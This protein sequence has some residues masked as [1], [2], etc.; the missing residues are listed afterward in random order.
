MHSEDSVH[1]LSLEGQT[2]VWQTA[3]QAP[4]RAALRY[5]KGVWLVGYALSNP[6]RLI[7]RESLA[8]WFW[9]DQDPGDGRRN[10]RVLLADVQQALRQLGQAQA[11]RV[12]RDWVRW[13]HP[14]RV[15]VALPPDMPPPP[16]AAETG[17]ADAAESVSE[18]FRSWW[19]H[20]DPGAPGTPTEAMASLRLVALVRVQWQRIDPL[21]ADAVGAGVG[22][23]PSAG[24]RDGMAELLE[25]FGARCVAGNAMA[26]TFVL[27]LGSASPSFRA[28]ALQ[29][30]G[31]LPAVAAPEGLPVRA[32]LCFGPVLVDGQGQPSGWRL[33]LV[34]RLAQVAE[35]G[36]LVC[37]HSYADQAD[38]LQFEALG[39]RAFRGFQRRFRLYRSPLGRLG[40]LMP[41]VLGQAHRPLVG[42]REPLQALQASLAAVGR[43][44]GSRLCWVRGAAGMGKTRLAVELWRTHAAG[45]Q[46]AAWIEGR[47]ETREQPWA[48]LRSWVVQ[49]L[50]AGGQALKRTQADL[51]RGFSVTGSVAQ[52][53][54]PRLREA[55]AALAGPEPRLWVLDDVQ[56]IDEASWQLLAQLMAEVPHS[57]WL[58]TQR[59][60]AEGAA[61]PCR[62]GAPPLPASVLDL[63]PLPDA[64][65]VALWSLVHGEASRPEDLPPGARAHLQAARGRPLYLLCALD[66]GGPAPHFAEYCQARCNALG[67]GRQVLELAALLGM[68]WRVE[69]LAALV[70]PEVLSVTLEA[71]VGLDLL[72]PRGGQWMAFFHPTLRDFL[73]DA[74]TAAQLQHH[75]RRVAPVRERQEE[76]ALAADLWQR[77][78][79][80]GRAQA[81]RIRA[82]LAAVDGDDH[83]AALTHF[84]ALRSQGYSTDA[85]QALTL[86][87][88]HAQARLV[89]KGYGDPLVQQLASE[90]GALAARAVAQGLPPAQDIRF[91][92]DFLQYLG[93]SSHGEL[94][95]PAAAQRLAAQAQTPAQRLVAAWAQGNT[96][97][98][99]GETAAAAQGL[100]EAVRLGDTVPLAERSALF[101]ADPVNFATAQWLWLRSLQGDDA[102]VLARDH[103]RAEARL[104]LQPQAQDRCVFHCMQ[105]FRCLT[106]GRPAA[107][108]AHA[109]QALLVAQAESY[110]LW[111]A[112]AQLQLLLAQA[113]QGQTV[114]VASLAGAEDAVRD[115]Y[116]AG[117][118]T[119]RWLLAELLRCTGQP[120]AALHLCAQ[121][122]AEQ[123]QQ[124]HRYCCMDIHR[125]QA[126]CLAALGQPAAARQAWARAFV[127]ARDRGLAGW[128][129]RWQGAGQPDAEAAVAAHDGC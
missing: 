30:A 103:A 53:E 58:L 107:M 100:A 63:A 71:A 79:E 7:Y 35:P 18:D 116:A 40:D 117:V 114:D 34:D 5:R 105:A 106:E 2:L 99:Y 42:R 102:A 85:A 36:E 22:A 60:P 12:E 9:P 94:G 24:V 37:D 113:L 82:A 128:L 89:V 3:R 28:A 62:D 120:E 50:G 29:F 39:E 86:C 76:W 95:G 16:A 93:S 44:E 27:G 121:W 38:F 110:D 77:A 41:A 14:G 21:T 73:L 97:F 46:A 98:W 57:L 19:M 83:H 127:V 65:A 70:P 13:E 101:V 17:G 109:Q 15:H 91:A 52:T 74:Q 49:R 10:L 126:Q 78:D 31:L 124:E 51:L 123:P 111:A 45:A 32:G 61:P 88:A 84:D 20:R 118:P 90:I 26:S 68:V 75:A 108:Q 64:D 129:R 81:C 43:G 87:L 11:L 6:G 47:P 122:L 112:I 33:R 8:E 59:V 119:A 72:V 1:H 54:R 92:V 96:A 48:S 69:D 104:A 66:E 4:L 56:W 23:Y 55:I 80:P 115:G 125:I 25:R 67:D